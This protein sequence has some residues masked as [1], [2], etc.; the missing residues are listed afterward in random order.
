MVIMLTK[1]Q[2]NEI[3]QKYDELEEQQQLASELLRTAQDR[4]N[5]V[6]VWIERE[7]KK[8]KVPQRYLWKEVKELGRGCQAEEVLKEKHPEVFEAYDKEAEIAKEINN[9]TF[10]YLG[11][12][13]HNQ[14]SL[15]DILH[16]VEA[17]IDL[18]K[19]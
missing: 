4:F 8:V 10:S 14:I 2:L 15:K 9:L 6:E 1:Q 13:K 16:L 19:D 11:I 12:A 18:K 3:Y 7:G 5:E 17:I